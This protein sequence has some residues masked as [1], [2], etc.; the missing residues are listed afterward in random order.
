MAPLMLAPRAMPQYSHQALRALMLPQAHMRSSPRDQNP[1][2]RPR[3]RLQTQCHKC[4]SCGA[5]SLSTKAS[6]PGMGSPPIPWPYRAACWLFTVTITR[7]LRRLP[8]RQLYLLDW[9]HSH[10]ADA[11]S[12]C[13]ERQTNQLGAQ[14]APSPHKPRLHSA[15]RCTPIPRRYWAAGWLTTDTIDAHVCTYVCTYRS[16]TASRFYTAGIRARVYLAVVP[17]ACPVFYRV[18]AASPRKLAIVMFSGLS[19]WKVKDLDFENPTVLVVFLLWD[20]VNQV[21]FPCFVF[22][23]FLDTRWAF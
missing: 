5:N 16:P 6:T 7:R 1:N 9:M 10:S 4:V 17:L 23:C 22:P 2:D 11:R 15:A 13:N 19:L 8:Q 3:L 21:L 14:S 18:L 20:W 12:Q